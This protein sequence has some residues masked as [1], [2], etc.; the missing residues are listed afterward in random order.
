VARLREARRLAP[1]DPLISGALQR[2]APWAAQEPQ[3]G[4]AVGSTA[5][6]TQGARGPT[7]S[8]R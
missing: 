6:A 8:R 1:G 3:P 7:R 2:L 4:P 5:S